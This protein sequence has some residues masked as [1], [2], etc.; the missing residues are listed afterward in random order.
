MLL[1]RFSP[2]RN[3]E[4]V[5]SIK[6][7]SCETWMIFYHQGQSYVINYWQEDILTGLGWSNT[8]AF[9]NH[10]KELNFKPIQG[11]FFCPYKG[12]AP[13]GAYKED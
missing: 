2:Y 1:S 7:T 10:M 6:G 5:K 11:F 8:K 13:E 9:F 4:E 3:I 12:A